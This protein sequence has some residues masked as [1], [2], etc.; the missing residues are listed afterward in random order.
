MS[1]LLG[2]A[3]KIRKDLGWE[4]T[5]DLMGLVQEMLSADIGRERTR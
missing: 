1:N 3:T 2:D 5:T 4:P